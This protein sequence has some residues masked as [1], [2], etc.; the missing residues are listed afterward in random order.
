MEKQIFFLDNDFDFVLK[1]G[2]K[3]KVELILSNRRIFQPSSGQIG[4]S[5][6]VGVV[7]NGAVSHQPLSSREHTTRPTSGGAGSSL[8]GALQLRRANSASTG[9]THNNNNN[10]AL[11]SSGAPSS[12]RVYSYPQKE[13]SIGATTI[14]Q[15]PFLNS[16]GVVVT[17]SN[18]M[19]SINNPQN[20]I[21]I[22]T[23]PQRQSTRGSTTSPH[24]RRSYPNGTKG[25]AVT[26]T[27][28]GAP[29]PPPPPGSPE[30]ELID[31]RL[32]IVKKGRLGMA[33]SEPSG[34]SVS[35]LTQSGPTANGVWSSA[36]PT[37]NINDRYLVA[38]Q[39]PSQPT[40]KLLLDT[41]LTPTT[42]APPPTALTPHFQRVTVYVPLHPA[43]PEIPNMD[44]KMTSTQPLDNDPIRSAAPLNAAEM[45]TLEVL[46]S[47]VMRLYFPT[48]YV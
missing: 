14:I 37:S 31:A 3:N 23:T 41:K 33:K 11:L 40:D 9:S 46:T 48:P 10:S 47:H 18:P 36:T 27:T 16:G 17:S 6:G 28:A 24:H 2:E 12:H 29:P 22:A 5:A 26:T 45:R 21:G 35:Q 15:Q 39:S 4:G 38:E 1:E 13:Q 42:P 34:S 19:Y 43:Y 7:G 8:Y 44:E 30:F 20:N 32:N 25:G